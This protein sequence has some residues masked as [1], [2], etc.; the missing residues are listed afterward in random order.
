MI[1]VRVGF[2]LKVWYESLDVF[3]FDDLGNDGVAD[4]GGEIATRDWYFP[5]FRE[6][7]KKDVVCFV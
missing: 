2:V 3:G 7:I 4:V 5:V 6:G 1:W